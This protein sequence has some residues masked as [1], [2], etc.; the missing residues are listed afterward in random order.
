MTVLRVNYVNLIDLDEPQFKLTKLKTKL[1]RIEIK[2]ER[3]ILNVPVS[4]IASALSFP[5]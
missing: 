4:V 5:D 2:I 3:L 1:R